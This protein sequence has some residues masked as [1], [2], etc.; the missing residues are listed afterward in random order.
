VNKATISLLS[1]KQADQIFIRDPNGNPV[2]VPLKVS[3]DHAFF[4]GA[5]THV[6]EL[7]QPMAGNW[8]VEGIYQQGVDGAFLLYAQ[9]DSTRIQD[10]EVKGKT[11]SKSIEFSQPA[12]LASNN[13]LKAI[14][15]ID[16]IPEKNNEG[17]QQV[18]KLR[19]HIPVQNT[20]I[21]L[22][23]VR[24]AGVYNVTIEFTGITLE[25]YPFKRTIVKTMYQ[26]Q[27]GQLFE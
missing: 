6:L 8:T 16:F 19:D 17:M 24:E 11:T 10:I 18:H 26:D 27:G 3:E 23:V 9:Y 12:A 14:H 4:D 5:W 13:V 20:H 22:P 15:S 7:N 2:P 1:D 25:G 21:S